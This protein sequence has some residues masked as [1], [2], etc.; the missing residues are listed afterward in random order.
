M[1]PRIALLSTNLA[2]GGAETEVFHLAVELQRRGWNPAVISLLPPT[3]FERELA[4]AGVEVHSPKMRPGVP[5]PLALARLFAILVRIRPHL[6]HSHMFH[7]NVLARLLRLVCPVPVVIST[8]HSIA[9]SARG[10]RG[11]RLRDLAYRVTDPLADA[12][13]AVSGAVAARHVTA[14]AVRPGELRVIPNGIDTAVFRPDIAR[15]A[16]IRRDLGVESA[17]VWLA[18]GRLM[19][20]KDYPTLLRAFAGQPGAVLL[21]AGEGPQEAE[22]RELARGLAVDVRFLGCRGDVAALM[23]AADGFVLS[24]VVEGLPL[25]LLEAAASGLPSVAADAGGVRDVVDDGAT[26]FVVPAGDA[27]ALAAAMSRL[28]GFSADARTEV[29]RAARSRA[30]ACFDLSVVAAQWEELYREL[31]TEAGVTPWT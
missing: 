8:I 12:V 5:D 28:A 13:T 1:K 18:A 16:N 15:R 11:V 31:L 9:E 3:A 14:G 24:S 26:G 30:V 6:L 22:L 17:F 4:K 19:W 23:N 29:S 2:S 25:A 20:K 21:I 7:A 27:A 10:S